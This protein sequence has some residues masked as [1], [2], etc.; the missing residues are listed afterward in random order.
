V[1]SYL[2]LSWD[3]GA[4]DGGLSRQAAGMAAQLAADGDEVVVVTRAAA[5]RPRPVG[6]AQCITVP[7]SPP[8]MTWQ[9]GGRVP[10]A[11]AFAA[12]AL[13]AVVG[14]HGGGA[15]DGR[16]PDVVVA[17]DWQAGLVARALGAVW[18][19]TFVQV[20][21]GLE[22][23]RRALGD[24]PD[25]DTEAV[26]DIEAATVAAA[27][28]VLA[29]GPSPA[30]VADACGVPL[31]AVTKLAFGV[32]LDDD[33]PAAAGNPSPVGSSSPVG[34][35]SPPD[36]EVATSR[37]RGLA[38]AA[39]AVL[40]PRGVGDP[41]V[42]ELA[43]VLGPGGDVV[44]LRRAPWPGT[45]P[46]VVVVHDVERVDV[47]IAAAAAGIPVVV[48]DLPELVGALQHVTTAVVAPVPAA[49]GEAVRGALADLRG[50]PA[51]GSAQPRREAVRAVLRAAGNGWAQVAADFRGA[52]GHA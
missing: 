28:V 47:A 37:S 32:E 24:V 3:I 35:P 10:H 50:A 44:D 27:D 6:A 20:V 1:T 14:H 15:A 22:V 52:V 13:A 25:Q 7:A 2:W 23:R 39:V 34:S 31:A 16:P 51:A 8:I 40:P 38:P 49:T 33:A 45:G 19:A 17:D 42:D 29:R 26:A 41:W 18:P 11:L 46:D 43:D 4:G 9:A 5:R 21:P 48:G 36:L 12:P 30:A